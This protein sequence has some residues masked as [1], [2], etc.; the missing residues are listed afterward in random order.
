M[1]AIAVALLVVLLAGCKG[2]PE[3]KSTLDNEKDKIS[4]ALGLNIGKRMKAD[5]L[6]IAPAMFVRGLQDAM[7][8]SS[9]KLLTDQEVKTVLVNLDQGLAMKRMVLSSAQADKNKKEGEAFLEENKKRPGVVTLPSGLQYEVIKE[10][11]GKTPRANQTVTTKYRGT[12]VNGT[13]FDSSELHGGTSTF[14]VNQV[15]P[16]WIE[17][18]Q[19]MKVGSKWKLFVP[20]QLAYGDKSAGP[21]I[22]PN[23]AL[24]FELE[25]IDVK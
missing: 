15:I 24:I 12:L 4:Y 13:E 3:S 17:A 16:G 11:S 23:S 22:G 21:T 7:D 25:L 10:G 20:A 6:E 19:R 9:K 14:Q 18:L 8:D 1:K 5:S 2:T